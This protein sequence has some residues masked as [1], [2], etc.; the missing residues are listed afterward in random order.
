MIHVAVGVV[1]NDLNRILISYRLKHLHQGG[2]WEFPGGKVKA[3]ESVE[4]ALK[5]ELNE[6]LGIE[7]IEAEPLL[8]IKYNYSDR[9][10]LLDVWKIKKF[11]G[12][13]EGREGQQ[14]VW[15]ERSKLSNY[16]FPAANSEILDILI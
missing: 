12:V 1:I 11:A 8:K 13:V 10:V 2:L 14:F 15:V 6:E 4:F 9:Q 7:V 5:R 16:E 3:G